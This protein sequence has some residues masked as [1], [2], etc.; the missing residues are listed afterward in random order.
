MYLPINCTTLAK[1]FKA[2]DQSWKSELPN[3]ITAKNFTLV[4]LRYKLARRFACK[5]TQCFKI[6]PEVTGSF[7]I[8]YS[9]MDSYKFL[10][11]LISNICNSCRDVFCYLY[12]KQKITGAELE[13]VQLNF[14]GM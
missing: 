9:Y 5:L 12:H 14:I 3:F 11:L 8:A 2:K 4:K 7:Q 10:W 6:K 13:D 1:S